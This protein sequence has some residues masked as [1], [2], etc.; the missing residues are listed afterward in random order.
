MDLKKIARPMTKDISKLAI[1]GASDS[2]CLGVF[3]IILVAYIQ[4][5]EKGYLTIDNLLAF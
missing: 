5:M 3:Y 2:F 1:N 4:Q